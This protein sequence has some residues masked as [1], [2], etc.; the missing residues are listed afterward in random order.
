GNTP[1]FPSAKRYAPLVPLRGFPYLGYFTPYSFP[2]AF[3]RVHL[4]LS[5]FLNLKFGVSPSSRVTN[6]PKSCIAGRSATHALAVT[7][8]TRF[9]RRRHAPQGVAGTLQ[10]PRRPRAPRVA[11]GPRRYRR[12][13]PPTRRQRHFQIGRRA[14]SRTAAQRPARP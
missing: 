10:D 12:R 4:R 1:Q 3:I 7:K 11:Q 13:S 9:Q 2:S 5:P 14:Q 6:H 8:A